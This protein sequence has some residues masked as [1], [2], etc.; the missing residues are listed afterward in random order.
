MGKKV[1]E[2]RKKKQGNLSDVVRSD[3]GVGLV[4]E[5]CLCVNSACV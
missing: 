1:S 2:Q 3:G 5:W 4:C